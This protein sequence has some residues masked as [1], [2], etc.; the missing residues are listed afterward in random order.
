H[1]ALRCFPASLQF[2]VPR[3]RSA[4]DTFRLRL[5]CHSLTC[6]VTHTAN[7][8]PS[9][10]IRVMLIIALTSE[11]V[12]PTQDFS[13]PLP[14]CFGPDNYS[15]VGSPILFA[16][17]VMVNVLSWMS[18]IRS[19]LRLSGESAR[20]G[21]ESAQTGAKIERSRRYEVHFDDE[22]PENGLR[23]IWLDAEGRYQ[24]A[25]RVH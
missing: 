5:R 1:A 22:L 15:G 13:R 7:L 8:M 16:F 18:S 3:C 20:S 12:R 14:F 10:K 6:G 17:M 24:G 21:A 23:Y 2:R 11:S 25:H 19:L 9:R 4:S